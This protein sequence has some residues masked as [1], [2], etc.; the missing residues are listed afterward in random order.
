MQNVWEN[1]GWKALH[2]SKSDFEQNYVAHEKL[3]KHL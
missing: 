1:L 2:N 3:K